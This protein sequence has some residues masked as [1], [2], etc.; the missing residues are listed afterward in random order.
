MTPGAQIQAAI[1]LLEDVNDA[2]DEGRAS[3]VDGMLGSYFR[4]RRYIGAKDKGFISRRVYNV[5]RQG[6]RLQWYIER[7]NLPISPRTLVLASLVMDENHPINILQTW[8][9]G[10]GHDAK[11]LHKDERNFVENPPLAAD[12]N[13]PE[14][15]R[16]NT[17]EWYLP[18]L[19]ETF[20]DDMEAEIEALNTEAPMDMRV[21]TLK[22]T[23]EEAMKALNKEG[24]FTTV[25]PYSPWGLRL[26]RRGAIFTTKT[27]NN[28]W[29]EIQDEGSQLV[30]LLA[31]PQPGQKVID[32]CAGAGGKTL[33]LAA[34]MQNKGRLMAWDT[35]ETR[36]KQSNKRFARAGVDNAQRH[37]LTSETDPF[38]KRHKN[39]A[40]IVVID[41]PCSG[42]GT[43]RRNPDLK[44]RFS[45][46]D[47]D[48]ILQVQQNILGSAQRLVKSGGK[49]LYIT[50]SVFNA[51]NE[52]QVKQFLSKHPDFTIADTPE[53]WNNHDCSKL[54]E[55]SDFLKLSPL[56]AGT[57]GFFAALLQKN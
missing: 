27:F 10:N 50:C 26:E 42:S 38:I 35:S 53:I 17:P 5:L 12:P 19:L 41:A 52:L 34:M 18:H 28:G 55:N 13:M 8:F 45:Q 37:V 47:L 54:M 14:W 49:L 4:H 25:T 22:A 57:D 3:P 48:E 30:A 36:L 7:G 33:A 16:L 44:W 31:A 24:F 11:P 29:L 51:E 23:R 6:G 15:M 43:W 9:T 32:F 46:Q 2:W 56:T 20:G 1:D 21:N 39:S 40:E